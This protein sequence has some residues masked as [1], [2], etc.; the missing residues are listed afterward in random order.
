MKQRLSVKTGKEN[1][2][3]SYHSTPA[4]RSPSL[5]A[6]TVEWDL[7]PFYQFPPWFPRPPLSSSHAKGSGLPSAY[8]T[9]SVSEG[10]FQTPV[11]P[12]S[13]VFLSFESRCGVS[14]WPFDLL[15]QEVNTVPALANGFQRCWMRVYL[16][17]YVNFRLWH[18][19]HYCVMHLESHCNEAN[20]ILLQSMRGKKSTQN[21]NH[22]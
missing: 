15:C 11:I 8:Y 13:T 20:H 1:R 10:R 12:G 4:W 7:L 6:I 19:G 3:D 16:I 2:H 5:K 14:P 21:G 17:N 9:L 18:K 22:S